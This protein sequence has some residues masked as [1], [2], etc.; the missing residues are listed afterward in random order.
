MARPKGRAKGPPAGLVLDGS[1]TLAWTF[2]DESDAYAD[3]VLDRLAA[4]RAVVPSLWPLE[5][6]NGLLMGERRRRSTEAQTIKWIAAL[7][8][9]PIDVDGETN[10]HAWGETLALARGHKLTAYDAAYLELAQRRRLPL[11]TLDRALRA[12]A[13]DCGVAL[14]GD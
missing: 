4:T 13:R 14:L 8:A 10:V 1:V 11:A 7:S 12:A 6:A 5:V 9:L 2:E 3:A